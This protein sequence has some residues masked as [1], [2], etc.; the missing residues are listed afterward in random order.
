MFVMMAIL[1][2]SYVSA[3][4]ISG[5]IYDEGLTKL[6]DV[7]VQVN[8]TPQ[9]T[10]VSKDGNYIFTLPKGAYKI[11]ADY[12]GISSVEENI[13]VAQEGNYVLDLI[14]FPTLEEVEEDTSELPEIAQEAEGF[15][16]VFI[17]IFIM[18]I[19]IIF[20]IIKKIKK[21]KLLLSVERQ[22]EES[23]KEDLNELISVVKKLGGRT[24]QKDLRK[25]LPYSEA[26]ISLMLTE[27][28]HKKKI[29]RIKKGRGNVIIL[30]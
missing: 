20:I 9:Q 19:I 29:E 30:R 23:S 3:A 11:T 27:L 4:T 5:G 6:K 8:S 17:V 14:L 22:I 7:V 28:E 26:K 18:I 21:P 2:T 24:T 25:E 16:P 15:S 13:T 10:M 1:V 12:K